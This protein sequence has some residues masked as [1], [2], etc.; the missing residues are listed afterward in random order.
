M[1]SITCNFLKPM[2]HVK[3]LIGQHSLQTV[4]VQNIVQH[5][6]QMAANV[7]QPSFNVLS[8]LCRQIQML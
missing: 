3:H 1:K 7:F 8:F 2:I 5:H 6:C 4:P